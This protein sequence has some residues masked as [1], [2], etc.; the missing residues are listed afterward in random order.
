MPPTRSW[1]VALGLAIAPAGPAA[2]FAHLWDFVEIYSNADGSVQFVEMFTTARSETFLPEVV[3][4]S[5]ASF[6]AGEPDFRF[7][8]GLVGSTANRRLLLASESFASSP[9]AVPP[10]FILPDHFLELGGDTLT[11]RN[12][13]LLTVAYDT[14]SWGP[15]L[16]LPLPGDGILSLQRVGS[17]PT[18][19]FEA[20][21]N[22]PTNFA[23]QT[24]ALVPEPASAALASLGLLVLAGLRRRRARQG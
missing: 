12:A 18:L 15:S 24:G 2:A 19:H 16:G 8:R 7:S 21:P 5:Q 22:S 6:A 3:I 1:L 11:L 10:D 9:G 4:R 23:G 17:G 13:G 20:L 14:L